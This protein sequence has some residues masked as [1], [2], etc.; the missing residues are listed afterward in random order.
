[1]RSQAT[2]VSALQLDPIRFCLISLSLSLATLRNEFKAK[3]EGTR[4][5][6]S[7]RRGGERPKK[8]DAINVQQQQPERFDVA[9]F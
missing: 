3:L 8:M 5:Q 6:M 2:K 1:M 7:A 4:A 9:H